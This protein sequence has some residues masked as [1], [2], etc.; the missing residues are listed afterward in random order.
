MINI[1][2]REFKLLADY[3]KSNYGINLKT[4]K[5]NLVLSRLQN[6]VLK[7]GFRNFTEYYDHLLAD[8]SGVSVVTLIDKITTNHTYFMREA[9][10]F[11]YFRDVV[12][13]SLKGCVKD[14]DL[15][16]WCAACSTGE[17]PYTLAM[18]I[19]EFFGE[20]KRYWDTQILATDISHDALETAIKGVYSS[21]RISPLPNRWK[22][23]YFSKYDKENYKIID[24]IKDD[25]IFR[26][27]NMTD[28][29]FPF[30]KKLH[31]IFCR[32]L[33]IY[34]DN[35]EKESLVDR[36]YNCLSDGGYFFISHSESINRDKTK[37]KLISP[38]VYRK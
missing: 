37:F 32:N 9:N 1:T 21:E 16:I 7:M 20:E 18:I 30:N 36:I 29:N 6:V 28:R 5:K 25:V 23:R 34:F 4:E 11:Y 12:L 38:G 27:I 24:R 14:K 22:L 19:D 26:K 10:H 3:I 15:R 13:P 31:V 33:M 8:T 35:Q 2:E 17:E